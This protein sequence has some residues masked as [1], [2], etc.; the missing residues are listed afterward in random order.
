[1]EIKM[2]QSLQDD[3]YEALELFAEQVFIFLSLLAIQRRLSCDE[4]YVLERAS[5]VMALVHPARD[6]PLH[7]HSAHSGA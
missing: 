2:P 6:V 7:R 3:H 5:K 1:M 4:L